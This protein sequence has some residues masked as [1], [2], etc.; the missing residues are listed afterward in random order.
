MQVGVPEVTSALFAGSVL[1]LVIN[2]KVYIYDYEANSWNTSIGIQHPVSHI[3]GDNCCYS[4]SSFCLDV[5][6]SV[7]AY[8]YGE[9]ASQANTYFSDSWGY[10]FQRFTF[11]NQE[12]LVGS[13][14]GIF[15]FHS[16]SQV[17]MLV[18]ENGE[19]KFGY[20]DHPLN[21]SF[22]LPFTHS[23]A[24]D[25]LVAPGQK[26]VLILWDEKNLLVSQNAGQL[27]GAVA[28]KEGDQVLFASF[29]EVNVTIHSIAANENELAVLSKENHFYYG[30]LGVLSSS[31]IK[32]LDQ[33][34]W[35]QDTALMF[36]HPGILE[37]LTPVPDAAD[38]AFDFQLCTMN[39][40]EILM[41]PQLNVD[42]CKVELLEGEFEDKMYT[43]DMNSKL[44]LSALMI[45][46]P[47]TSPIPIV[48]VSNPH[49]LG[50]QVVTYEDGYTYDGNTKHRLN[51]SLKQQQH[52]GRADPNFTSSIKQ[53]TLSTV[54]LDIANKEI[55]CV[56]LRP[57]TALISVGCDLEKKLVIQNEVSA[58]SKGILDP[59]ALQDN[60]TY[61]IERDYYDPHF[62]GQKAAEDLAV[63]YPYE[64]LGCPRLVYYDTPWKPVV[65]LWREGRFQEVISTEYVLLEVSGQFAYT[66]SLTAKEA[67]CKSQPQNWSTVLGSTD[68]KGPYAWDRENYVSCHEPNDD[69]PLRWPEVP[70]EIMGGSTSN[71]II[72]DQRNGIYVFTLS[73]VDPYYSYCHLRTTFSIYVYG[74]FPAPTFV[75]EATILLLML[76][77][78]LAVWLAYA[79]PKTL[80]PEA[81]AGIKG[82]WVGLLR[83]CK[84]PCACP[85]PAR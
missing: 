25:V 61:V 12:N 6:N 34:I 28:V 54:T 52:W 71:R 2:R 5:S 44:E 40:Q 55:S 75:P 83:R 36:D 41:D 19:A 80:Q 73:I 74:A 32:L 7:F 42:V 37:V 29:S 31:L 59:V 8:M 11:T 17:G 63:F 72:F 67:L 84:P 60:Y 43:I 13:L 4:R 56:D 68:N 62:L 78:L 9:T 15:Y 47:G 27:V 65:E 30:S 14:G 69:A 81:G 23:G 48:T 53:P 20:A 70:Y 79:V 51:I 16:L 35:T 58:C 82:L 24:L 18:T 38:P 1:L 26:G 21:R 77:I 76:S 64:T 49:S 33:N 45:P 50:L 57:L 10:Q 85:R 66:Y 39:I 22:G 3:S 46:R